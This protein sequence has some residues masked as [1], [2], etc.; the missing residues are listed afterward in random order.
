MSTLVFYP[1]A[2]L[3]VLCAVGVVAARNPI[4]SALWLVATLFL[5]AVGYAALSAHLVAA[6]QIIIYAGA[7]MVLF[8]FVIML[9]NLQSDPTESWK[10]L[11][12]ALAV[13][14]ATT[15]AIVVGASVWKAS[16][17][18]TSR[19]VLDEAFGTTRGLGE[20]LFR[21]H[22][23]AFELTSLFLLVAV[24]GAV[25]LAQKDEPGD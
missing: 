3:T 10:P 17:H 19:A 7:V 6:L 2:A 22:V 5:V 4:H 25:V 24:V 11:P 8:L 16:L 13:L 12:T 18:D 15:L 21:N 14:A 1:L 23:V 20:V 9:L